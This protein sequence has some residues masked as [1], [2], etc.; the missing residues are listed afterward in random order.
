ML[1]KEKPE[2]NTLEMVSLERLVPQGHLLRKIDS[3]NI[4]IC[5]QV[6]LTGLSVMV[7]RNERYNGKVQISVWIFLKVCCGTKNIA[8]RIDTANRH[9]QLGRIF[10]L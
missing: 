4:G 9:G 2:R 8:V 5:D 10:V 1:I 6:R 7:R 3:A